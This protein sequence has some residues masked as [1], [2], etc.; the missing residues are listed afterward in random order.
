MTR[1][2]QART[3]ALRD[4]HPVPH[5]LLN[6][7]R[8]AKE[9]AA[10]FLAQPFRVAHLPVEQPGVMQLGEIRQGIA[11]APCRQ[12]DAGQRPNVE[13]KT[14]FRWAI[15]TDTGVRLRPCAVKQRQ[16][17]VVDEVRKTR[18]GR[19]TVVPHTGQCVLGEV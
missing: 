8:E 5:E 19:V 17:A 18:K 11:I 14:V 3:I 7:D 4:L 10:Q 9:P 2:S 13:A 15:E 6:Q 12:A 16:K 1:Q